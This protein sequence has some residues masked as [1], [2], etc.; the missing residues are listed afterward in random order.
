[1]KKADNAK[2]IRLSCTA[3]QLINQ[4]TARSGCLHGYFGAS[5]KLKIR[6]T[7]NVD[8][9]GSGASAYHGTDRS[10]FTATG[11]GTDERADGC[12]NGCSCDGTI[13]LIVIVTHCTFG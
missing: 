1:M 5:R 7:L 10:A 3:P 4:L 6:S 9:P 12:T 11:N 8:R 13:S 2:V